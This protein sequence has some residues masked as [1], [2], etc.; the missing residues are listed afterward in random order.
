MNFIGILMYLINNKKYDLNLIIVFE[1]L[2]EERSVTRAAERACLSQSAMSHALARLREMLQDPVLVRGKNGMEPTERALALRGPIGKTLIEL[3]E[4]LT[5]PKAFD[6]ATDARCF[7]LLATDYAETVL[8]NSIIEQLAEKGPH[9]R[10]AFRK[11]SPENM[12]A[13][14]SG[15]IDFFIGRA[16]KK[17]V[18]LEDTTLFDDH[19]CTV[20]R[21]DHP[22][23]GKRLTQKQYLGMQHVVLSPTEESTDIVDKLLAKKGLRRTIAI[24]TPYI[25]NLLSMVKNSDMIATIPRRIPVGY[26]DSHRLKIYKPPIDI[27]GFGVCLSWHEKRRYDGGHHWLRNLIQTVA[28]DL[29]SA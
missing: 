8:V 12:V 26:T 23:L 14:E 6:P 10:L 25:T 11:I 18:Y 2:M 17:K 4:V 20:V 27:P 16:P 28:T 3:D 13:F 1:L 5:P 29:A 22:G 24:S 15:E 19:Y 9:I 7:S 21:K